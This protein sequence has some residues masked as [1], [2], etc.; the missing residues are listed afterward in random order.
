MR[1]HHSY[2][3][4]YLTIFVLA[5]CYELGSGLTNYTIDITSNRSLTI[6]AVCNVILRCLDGNV[7]LV[8]S[9]N[10]TCDSSEASVITCNQLMSGSSAS[11]TCANSVLNLNVN[12]S[13]VI[14]M[15]EN[16][17]AVDVLRRTRQLPCTPVVS[18]DVTSIV[19][20]E[21]YFDMLTNVSDMMSDD[22]TLTVRSKQYGR[23][24]C[25]GHHDPDGLLYNAYGGPRF[26][27][28][29][30]NHKVTVNQDAELL[31]SPSFY[32]AV[33]FKWIFEFEINGSREVPCVNQSQRVTD[34]IR[35]SC[36][37]NSSTLIIEDTEFDDAGVYWCEASHQYNGRNKTF[38]LSIKSQLTPLWPAIGIILE[39]SLVAII[40]L[41]HEYYQRHQQKKTPGSPFIDPPET[42]TKDDD[43]EAYNFPSVSND[44][45]SHDKRHRIG[46]ITQQSLLP[47]PVQ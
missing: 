10:I 45:P 24:R 8:V 44:R 42:E 46:S 1:K 28:T 21:R 13:A 3:V 25:Y 27:D 41:G 34:R 29:N 37:M 39:L 47:D 18:C 20:W 30:E 35:L 22:G 17:T 14:Y 2:S 36:T 16:G 40:I 9:E 7:M 6:P 31:C 12:Q 33:N 19:R 5:W 4:C 38:H 15:E 23:Y 26:A 43:T 11:F 32:P